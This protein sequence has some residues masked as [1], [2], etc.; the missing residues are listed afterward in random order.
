MIEFFLFVIQIHKIANE[1]DV[2]F[3]FLKV[4]GKL[5]DGTGLGNVFE[6]AGEH[7]LID[8]TFYGL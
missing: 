2:V 5:I 7:K 4:I 1:P 3:C 6:D 8:Q